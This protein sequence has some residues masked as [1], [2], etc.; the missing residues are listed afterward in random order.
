MRI[1]LR[2]DI[3][4]LGQMGEVVNV[5]DG[6]ARNFLIPKNKALPATPSNLRV[7]EEEKKQKAVRTNKQKIEAEK[8]ALQFVNL[9]VTASVKVGEE[10]KV[11]GSITS[12]DIV[13]L[14]TE[15]GIE[16]DKKKIVLDEPIKAL[17]IYDVKI[18]LHPEVETTVKVWVVK[19]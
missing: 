4:K 9:S 15:K 13:A 1:I 17:G 7:L 11:F 16:I 19:E 3:D 18:K 14:I 8:M 5:K 6:Y 12:Q 10:D 2:E